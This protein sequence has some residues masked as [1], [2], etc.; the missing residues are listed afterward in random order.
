MIFQLQKQNFRIFRIKFKNA[1]AE[2]RGFQINFCICNALGE[3]IQIIVCICYSLGGFFWMNFC[4]C[5][6][7]GRSLEL[8]SVSVKCSVRLGELISVSVILQ[9]DIVFRIMLL[10]LHLFHVDFPDAFLYKCVGGCERHGNPRCLW[11]VWKVMHWKPSE[12]GVFN[13]NPWN[14]G[15]FWDQHRKCVFCWKWMERKRAV[16]VD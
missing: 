10:Y 4:V 8:I 1:D 16:S 13:A 15:V 9:G 2:T 11:D 14:S 5:N 3:F 12:H 7:S 6:F